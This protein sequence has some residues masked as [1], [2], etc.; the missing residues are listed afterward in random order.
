VLT[1]APDDARAAQ[2]KLGLV[3]ADILAAVSA[4]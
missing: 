2:E 1:R 3:V 4:L